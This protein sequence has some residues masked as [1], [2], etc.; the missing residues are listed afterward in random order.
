MTVNADGSLGAAFSGDTTGFALIP[1]V[2]HAYKSAGTDLASFVA[3]AAVPAPASWSMVLG[4]LALVGLVVHRRAA[5]ARESASAGE[6][7]GLGA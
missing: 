7:G 5:L 1:G 3:P 6:A 2:L 4:G